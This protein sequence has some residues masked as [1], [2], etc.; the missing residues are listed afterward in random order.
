MAS[1]DWSQ[2]PAVESTPGKVSG[3][4][5][6]K[7]GHHQSGQSNARL[8]PGNFAPVARCI[9][10]G[11]LTVANWSAMALRGPPFKSMGVSQV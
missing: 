5:V 11:G 2:C 7:E 1:P 4:W 9:Y 8:P 3:A 6:A 10:V